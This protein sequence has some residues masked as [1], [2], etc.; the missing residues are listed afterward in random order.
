VV[1]GLTPP[2]WE[3]NVIDENIEPV[4]YTSMPR[5]DLVGLTA[6]TSQAVRAYEI[7]AD[8][9]S[10][11]IPVVMGG[12]HTS[13]CVEEALEHV[14][15]VVIGEAESVWADVLSDAE[16]GSLKRIYRGT[17]EAMDK[18]PI[19]RHDLLPPA[20]YCG[21]I[22]T[23]RGC[24]LDCS[25]CSVTAFNGRRYR[26]RPIK[27]VIEEL[28]LIREKFVLFVDDNLIGTRKEHMDRAKKLFRAMIKADLGKKWMTQVTINMADDEELLSLAAESGCFGVYIGIESISENGLVELKKQ[29]NIKKTDI[30]KKS[31]RRFHRYNILVC[32]SF[33]MGL[34]VDDKGIG[35]R[36]AT[37]ARFWGMD[38]I[39]LQFMTPLPGTRLWKKMKAEGRIIANNFPE[40]WKYYNL[41]F[42]VASYK[43]FSWPEIRQEMNVCYKDFYSY[44]RILKRGINVLFRMKKIGRLLILLIF[45]L[46]FRRDMKLE[47]NSLP[48]VQVKNM[49]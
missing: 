45:S 14:D 41:T 13:M 42:P 4:D 37:A 9:R 8:F 2:E 35:K 5:P 26:R 3:I 38:A 27:N 32:G 28:K 29:F 30:L 7:A 46:G 40:D 47:W 31:I 36:I 15:S 16:R 19:A 18:S 39:S 23:T 21:S 17:H 1:A 33:I 34:D 44:I 20:Y 6:F 49:G 11:G 25:F 22:Q 10:R 24:P 48:E 43:N 12:I